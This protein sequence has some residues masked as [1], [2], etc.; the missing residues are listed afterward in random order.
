MTRRL[1]LTADRD[2]LVEQW[3]PDA[4]FLFCIPGQIIAQ[5]D[6]IRF[7]L[8]PEAQAPQAV[9]LPRRRGRPPKVR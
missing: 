9:E 8:V 5:A 4:A 7:G 6:A 2:R 1:W 3:D